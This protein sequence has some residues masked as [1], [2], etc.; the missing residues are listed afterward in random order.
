M[1]PIVKINQQFH[2]APMVRKEK[3]PYGYNRGW[4]WDFLLNTPDSK[5]K[6][7]YPIPN[8]RFLTVQNDYGKPE[9]FLEKLPV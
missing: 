6:K 7:I 1:M 3:L 9:W 2:E 4:Y 8:Q 5:I